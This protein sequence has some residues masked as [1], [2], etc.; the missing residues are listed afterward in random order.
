MGWG[1]L[2]AAM[3]ITHCL[4]LLMLYNIVDDVDYGP[5]SDWRV[6]IAGQWVMIMSSSH[7]SDWW[8]AGFGNF[9]SSTS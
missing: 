8:G 3:L 6:G 2:V 1:V 7:R 9:L 5:A 4:L